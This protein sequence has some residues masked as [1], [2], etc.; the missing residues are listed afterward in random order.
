MRTA[1][2]ISGRGSNADAL[3]SML[4]QDNTPG[5]A[6]LLV[7]NRPDAGGLALGDKYGVPAVIVD[8]TD[9]DTRDAF[10]DALHDVLKEY[11]IE[12]VCL[13]GFMRLLNADFVNRWRDRLVNIHPSLLP[14]YKGLETHAR[15]IE[16]GARIAG[17]TVHFVRPEMDTGPI[18]GQA[19]VPVL[20]DDT[21]ESLAARTLAAEH[22][23]YPYC[24]RLIAEKRVRVKEKRV[25]IDECPIPNGILM[26]PS[27]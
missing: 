12:L 10:E 17:C 4:T 14:A 9:Y 16:D 5:V 19:A 24:V 3:L 27:A 22:Q 8:H 7:S 1:I 11:E 6:S 20:Q 2:L 15:A 26:M 13:A 23:L 18:I 21:P 25:L